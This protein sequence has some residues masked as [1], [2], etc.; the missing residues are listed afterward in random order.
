ML[1]ILNPFYIYIF[2]F[3]I[4]LIV[5]SIP[6]SNLGNGISGMLYIFFIITFIISFFIGYLLKKKQLFVYYDIKSEKKNRENITILF[7]FI[8]YILEA[9]YSNGFPIFSILGLGNLTYKDFGIP[10]LH[11]FLVTFHSFYLTYYL[12]KII[13]SINKSKIVKMILLFIPT[14]LILNRGMLMM[15]FFSVVLLIGMKYLGNFNKRTI[16]IGLGIVVSTLLL[17]YVFGLL[18][19]LRS[20]DYLEGSEKAYNTEYIMIIGE[21]TNEFHDS[22]I[23]KP[24][25]WSYLYIA[26]PIYNLQLNI[27]TVRSDYSFKNLFVGSLLPDF[28]NKRIV[29]GYDIQ[30]NEIFLVSPGLTVATVFG[31]TFADLSWLGMW[32]FIGFIFV[33]SAI[34]LIILKQISPRF[35]ITGLVLVSTML[36]FFLFSNMWEYSAFSFQLIYPILMSFIKNK[37]I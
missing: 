26:S 11:V 17:F 37:N 25:F 9:I 27:D 8:L 23:P 1:K 3:S 12:H 22:N 31:Q 28:I 32:I 16:K 19:N 36:S 6:W 29:S 2:T 35:F 24:F 10:V 14:I 13:G 21:A 4:V 7:I 18:G 15:L 30:L 33:F 5:A 20:N 34:Y